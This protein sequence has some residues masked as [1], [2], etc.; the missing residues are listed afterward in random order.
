MSVADFVKT[1]EDDKDF[2]FDLKHSK[3]MYVDEGMV[4]PDGPLTEAALIVAG[5]TGN[6]AP[7][8][9]DPIDVTQFL[10][11]HSRPGAPR[12]ILLDFTGHTTTG[13]AWNAVSGRPASIV[14]PPYSTDADTTTFTDTEK[15]NIIAIWRAVAEDYAPFDVDVT[16][17]EYDAAGNPISIVDKG[18]RAIIGGSSMDWYGASAGGVA[19]VG[20]FGAAF[21]EGAFVFPAQ[22]GN[23]AVK[24][25]AEAISHEVGVSN[26]RLPC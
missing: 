16:T 18:S 17:D 9:A 6:A 5:A 2:A 26:R 15:R 14:T 7:G 4:A 21:Y 23:G 25:V 12:T 1:A 22:L 19:Y 11:L 13:T 10:K 3:A 8:Q 24:Y 20:V